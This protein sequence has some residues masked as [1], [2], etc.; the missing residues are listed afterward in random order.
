MPTEEEWYELFQ[1]TT[2]EW[3]TQYG[4][5]G[6]RFTASNGNSLFLPAAGQR[7]DKLDYDAGSCGYYW[8]SSLCTGDSFCAEYLYFLSA[9]AGV[10]GYS[11]YY[12]FS[13]RPVREN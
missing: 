8:S 13:V 4:V 2:N 7:W 10:Y 11:R 12:G 6:R 3:T 5:Y 1:N 9:Y